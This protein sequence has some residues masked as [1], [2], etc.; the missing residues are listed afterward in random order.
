MLKGTVARSAALDT[1]MLHQAVILVHDQMT[2]HNAE[3][4]EDH[5]YEDEQRGASEELGKT[6]VEATYMRD[7]RQ[8]SHY[9]E[10]Y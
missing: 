3:S 7:C 1:S 2:F 6:T 8:N 4:I 5:A 9:S 10:E